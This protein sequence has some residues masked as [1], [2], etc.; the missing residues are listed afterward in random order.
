MKL[1]S[2]GILILLMLIPVSMI[3]G[4]IREREYR[5]KDAIKEVSQKWGENQTVKGLVLTVPYKSYEKVYDANNNSRLVETIEYAHFL[6]DLLQIKGELSPEVRYRGIYEVIVYNSDLT[7]EGNFLSPDFESLKID[8]DH[9]VWED[10]FISLGLSDLRSIQNEISIMWDGK[11]IAFNPG[12]ETSDVI[13]SGISAKLSSLKPDDT[14]QK[15][16]FALHLNF[17]EVVV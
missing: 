8:P 7:I 10:A 2:M 16:Q 11:Q 1:I 3:E 4:L 9:A 12:V 13:T 17:M 5:Q 15:H 14:P 6:P